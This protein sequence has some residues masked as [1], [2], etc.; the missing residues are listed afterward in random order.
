MFWAF[1]K[2]HMTKTWAEEAPG[3][4]KDHVWFVRARY[5]THA[6]LSIHTQSF[7]SCSF[8]SFLVDV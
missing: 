8:S 2:S 3:K 6:T 7:P 1:S 4:G 5:T